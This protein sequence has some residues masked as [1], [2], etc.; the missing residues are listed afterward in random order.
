[1]GIRSRLKKLLTRSPAPTE[2][3]K[4]GQAVRQTGKP[5]P[6]PEK[7]R[8]TRAPERTSGPVKTD[9]KASKIPEGP[10]NLDTAS[11]KSAEPAAKT[12]AAAPNTDE[13]KKLA[14]QK[15]AVE[16]A[17]RGTLQFLV[18]AGGESQL[19]DMHDHSERKYFVAHR[20]F[21]RLM[22]DL[23]D[24]G[25]VDFNHTTGQAII[26]QAGRDYLT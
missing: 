12:P 14:R 18:D 10:A 25:L 16:R 3:P 13:A 7:Y 26:T 11:P 21:S 1:M 5:K 24:T 20:G 23:T 9:I 8:T 2:G 15:R 22:E 19:A 17:K 6:P 4:P